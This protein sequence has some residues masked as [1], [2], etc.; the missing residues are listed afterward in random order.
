[1]NLKAVLF[2]MDGVLFDSMPN[3]A[4]AW[5]KAMTL[6][7]I[8]MTREEA[9]ATEGQRGV[10]TIR[11]MMKE[12]LGKELSLEQAQKIYNEKTQF[13]H[14]LPEAPVM[15]GI[16]KLMEKIHQSGINIG[17]VTGSGQLPL[18]NRLLKEFGRYLDREHI[19]TAY[20]VAKGKPAPD[21][22]LKGLEMMG[23]LKA[24]EAVV[25]EN[26]PLGVQAGVAA[27]IYTICV[28]TGHLPTEVFVEKGANIIFNSMVAL[29]EN[30][31]SDFFLTPSLD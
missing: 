8:E 25:V 20:N 16:K 31:E 18:I 19:V 14:E 3:H 2:D 7:G 12:R 29:S 26:A 1:M 10:D 15:P 13:F 4:I 11:Q 23:D 27:G 6:H 30:W 9:Y 17:V 22:Y 24:N 28:N 21:P 5:R